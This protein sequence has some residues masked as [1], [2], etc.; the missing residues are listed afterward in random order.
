[1]KKILT[2]TLIALL[3][4][5]TH[6]QKSYADDEDAISSDNSPKPESH[7]IADVD[8]EKQRK[9]SL[10]GKLTNLRLANVYILDSS[11]YCNQFLNQKVKI[12]ASRPPSDLVL[13]RLSA[14]QLGVFPVVAD[15]PEGDVD[16][17]FWIVEN[18]TED[19]EL[20]TRDYM[21]IYTFKIE[22]IK[23]NDTKPKT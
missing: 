19:D 12:T 2:L 7:C 5:T 20:V 21:H 18:F 13:K 6:A 14:I 15:A 8:I 22:Q 9:G 17:N 23:A 16:Y 1:M 10:T 3:F 4:I 11:K